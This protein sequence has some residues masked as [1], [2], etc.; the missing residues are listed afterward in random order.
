MDI[1]RTPESRFED[2][3]DYPFAP[4]FV[5]LD[6]GEGASLRMHY[7]DEGEG[8]VIL[9]LHG[10]PSWSYLYR[11]M[12]PLL[13]E[14]GYR[15]VAPDL[16]GFGKSDK[17]TQRSDYTYASHVF[18][19]TG[20]VK[21]LDLNGITLVCQDWGSLIGLRVVAENEHRFAR[22]VLGNGGLPDGT[23]I[24]DSMTPQLNAL[25]A[26]TPALSAEEMFKKLSGPMEDR[27]QFMYWVRHCDA[28]PDFHPAVV[29][30][31]NLKHCDEDE[32]RAWAAPFPSEAYMAGARQFPS[33]VPIIPDNPAIPANKAAW[34]VFERFDKP[35]ITVFSDS[36]PVTR[37]GEKRWIAAVPGAQGQAHTLIEGAG[38]FLQDDAS[39][40]LTEIVVSF[41][42]SNSV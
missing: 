34:Q 10:Q 12:I 8:E 2:L 40:A 19:M 4:N 38:H 25:L 30:K 36:D 5:E 3:K 24:P 18:W 15:V 7:L 11:K 27:P 33:L 22:V 42:R 9:C 13:V 29:M 16:V 1:M 32:Y 28:H 23:G 21:A 39:A 37:G 17:P 14:A 35:F 20:F 26:S 6:D 31:M 41:M